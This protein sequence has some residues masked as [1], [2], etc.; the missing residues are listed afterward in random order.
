M[1]SN[2]SKKFVNSLGG[3]LA[4]FAVLSL[5]V[6]CGEENREAN[7]EETPVV[8]VEQEPVA[9][10]EEWDYENTDWEEAGDN[11]CGSKAQ[12]PVNIVSEEVIEADLADL[13]YDYKPFNIVVVDNGHTV[14]VSG[15]KDNI[16]TVEGKKF[17]FKQLHFHNPSEH[18]IDG[19]AYPMEMHL[20]HQE[21]GKDNLVVLGIFIEEGGSNEF[22]E[23][24]FTQIPSEEG[25]EKE[26]ENTIDLN[27][28]LPKDKTYYTYLGSLTTPPCSVGV[29]WK[30]FKDP[31]TASA[32]QIDQ[33]AERYA[34]TARPVQDLDN[35]RVLKSMK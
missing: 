32:E 34:N 13:N 9:G 27:N 16:I 2:A 26:T 4:V 3:F 8:E 33:F 20:V 17:E 31:I 7:V 1:I 24:V 22:L 6:S 14:Q 28:L 25:V 15:A 18:T 30:V 21:E 23:N 19:N 5:S 29:D 10:A 35:R 11:E 12:S